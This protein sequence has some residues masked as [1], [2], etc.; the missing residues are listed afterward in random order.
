[1]PRKCARDVRSQTGSI[2]GNS[3]LDV[4]GQGPQGN[5]HGDSSEGAVTETDRPAGAAHGHVGGGC[6]PTYRHM[7]ASRWGECHCH[8]TEGGPLNL[9]RRNFISRIVLP[10]HRLGQDRACNGGRMESDTFRAKTDAPCGCI[11]NCGG[12]CARVSVSLNRRPSR[13]GGIRRFSVDRNCQLRRCP[14][15]DH[16]LV[17]DLL[18]FTVGER[19]GKRRAGFTGGVLGIG[20]ERVTDMEVA[21]MQVERGGP[22]KSSNIH[23]GQ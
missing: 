23:A 20:T 5:R 2:M 8:H 9:Y 10:L 1:M 13:R 11:R 19:R 21:D 16:S 22:G 12:I 3:E 14:L 6:C 17:E 15:Q 4:A 18:I 7:H